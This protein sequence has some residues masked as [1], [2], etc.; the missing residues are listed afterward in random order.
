MN[1]S[2]SFQ[3]ANA[4]ALRLLAHRPRSEAEIR[5]RLRRRF[6][7]SV[8]DAVVVALHEQ[9][10]LDDARFARMWRESRDS[11]RPRSAASIRQELIS[12]GVDRE[13]AEEAVQD[14][15]DEESAYRAAER[16]ARRL[17]QA[18]FGAFRSRLWGHLRRR[19][20]S[21]SV[22]RQTI[23]RLWE[24]RG[25]EDAGNHARDLDQNP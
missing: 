22:A 4:T 25:H 13:I 11:H 21:A 9:G 5:A 20:Y 19:G 6:H 16:F 18:D 7:P 10:L 12:K 2:E 23:D 1:D 3:Q 14:L 17:G 24:S 8:V 15:D